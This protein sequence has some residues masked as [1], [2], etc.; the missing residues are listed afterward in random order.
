MV[1]VITVVTSALILQEK[2]TALAGVG[3]MMTLA[4]LVLSE[5]KQ[6]I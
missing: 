6:K 1:P 3:T 4:G 5:R 2:I